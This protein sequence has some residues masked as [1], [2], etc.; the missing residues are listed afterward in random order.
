[1]LYVIEQYTVVI[2]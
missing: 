1:M 2:V